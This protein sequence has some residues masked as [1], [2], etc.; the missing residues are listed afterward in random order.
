MSLS[1][2]IEP[3][4]NPIRP[5]IPIDSGPVSGDRSVDRRTLPVGGQMELPIERARGSLPA[6]VLQRQVPPALLDRALH[7]PVSIRIPVP[8]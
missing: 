1:L 2:G 4:P 3:I 5:V 8:I 7:R 6:L